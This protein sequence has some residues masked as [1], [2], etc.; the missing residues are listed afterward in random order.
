VRFANR[1]LAI[2]HDIADRWARL[3]AQASA[4]NTALPVVDGLLAPTALHH[5]LTL[6]TRNTKHVVATGVPLF[7]PWTE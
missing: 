4:R 2:D 7:N 3:A 6:V 5:N 1:I